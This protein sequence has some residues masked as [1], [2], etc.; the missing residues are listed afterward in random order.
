[1]VRPFYISYHQPRDLVKL[2]QCVLT[3]PFIFIRSRWRVQLF[4]CMD[5][6]SSIV[7]IGAG[8]GANFGYYP[9]NSRVICVEPMAEF[10]EF[11][12]KN[13]TKWVE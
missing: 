2:L 4:G 3:Q 12:Q 9:A 10:T 8:G 7:E 11:A 5:L 6:S 13:V 1:M